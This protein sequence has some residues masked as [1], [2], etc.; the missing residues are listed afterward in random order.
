M[1]RMYYLTDSLDSCEQI[2][3]D[4]HEA[5]INDGH[6]HV[7]SK[8]VAGLYKRHIHSANYLQTL[9][10]VRNLERGAMVGFILAVLVTTW[11]ATQKTFGEGSGLMYFAIF[12]FVTLFGAW[13]GGLVGVSTENQKI[14]NFHDEI[15]SGK[16]LVMVDLKAEQVES[17]ESLMKQKHPQVPL[18]RVGSTRINPFRFA[19]SNAGAA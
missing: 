7:L 17:V 4:I 9:D 5:G 18:K 19:S 16:F 3:R 8:D 12:G 15:E 6:F 14:R 10:I 2:S 1:K 13:A 11:V